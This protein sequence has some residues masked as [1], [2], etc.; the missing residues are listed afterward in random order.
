[1]L[2]TD[3]IT[4]WRDAELI[5]STGEKIGNIDE[6]YVDDDTGKPEFAVVK[7]GFLGITGAR[8]VPLQQEAWDEDART[9]RVGWNKDTIKD[10]PDFPVDGDLSDAQETE[11]YRYYG[12]DRS[13]SRSDSG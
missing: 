8:F 12:I 13:E 4:D 1:M 10:S 2:G 9:I 7:T 6:L 11:I 5:D 3:R